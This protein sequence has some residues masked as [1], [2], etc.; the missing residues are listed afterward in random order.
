[1]LFFLQLSIA[2][3]Q[4]GKQKLKEFRENPKWK[5]MMT[6]PNANFYETNVAFE[7]F[8]KGKPNPLELMEGEK[9]VLEELKERSFFSRLF[10]SNRKL[11]KESLEYAVDFKKFKFWKIKNEGFVKSDGRVMTQDQIQEMVQQELQ[12]RQIKKN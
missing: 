4:I 10:K 3:S 12:S 9:E 11:K 8:W 5:E 6:D 2:Q 7:E 1:L